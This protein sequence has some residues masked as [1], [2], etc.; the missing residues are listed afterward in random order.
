MDLNVTSRRLVERPGVGSLRFFDH[1]IA[2]RECAEGMGL[3]TT[4]DIP[5]GTV[6]WMS[7]PEGEIVRRQLSLDDVALSTLLE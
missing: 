3:V 5:W 1:R 2:L 6:V 7:D 4:V